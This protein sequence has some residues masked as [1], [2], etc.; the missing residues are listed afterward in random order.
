[1]SLSDSSQS[2]DQT[3]QAGSVGCKDAGQLAALQGVCVCV[4]AFVAF[5]YLYVTPFV[6]FCA[7]I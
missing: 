4:C 1:M 6:C 3:A 5:M 2:C 7:G